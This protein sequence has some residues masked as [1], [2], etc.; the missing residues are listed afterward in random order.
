MIVKDP[1][2]AGEEDERPE[3]VHKCLHFCSR[4]DEMRGVLYDPRLQTS[5]C[6]LRANLVFTQLS[7]RQF[8]ALFRL[9]VCHVVCG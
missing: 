3:V 5:T 8:V 7:C 9:W 6:T 4:H 1:P 2:E